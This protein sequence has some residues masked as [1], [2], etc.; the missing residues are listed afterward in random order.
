MSQA[1]GI[2]RY[3]L[4]HYVDPARAAGEDELTIRAGDVCRAM[5]LQG[6]TPNVCSVLGSRKFLEMAGLR[7]LGRV[8]PAQSTTTTYCYALGGQKIDTESAPTTGAGTAGRRAGERPDPAVQRRGQIGDVKPIVVIACAGSKSA[9][10]GHLTLGNGRRI[11]FVADPRV[12]PR[13]GSTSY[14]HPDDAAHSGLTWR[15]VLAG[16]NRSP[17]GNPRGLL[18]AWRLYEP[19][20]YPRVY[21]DLV[22]MYG[23]GNV[24]ILSAGWGLVAAGFLLPDYDITFAAAA[25]PEKRRRRHHRFDDFA[26]L[27]KMTTHP[28]VFMGGKDYVQLFCSLTEKAATRKIVF[29]YS[30]VPPVATG[31]ELRRY[32]A[33]DASPRTWH[34]QCAYALMRGDVG[35]DAS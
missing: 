35:I 21:S 14:R 10:T 28:V 4:T 17:E 9:S 20:T 33:A 6:R 30:S 8:G 22:E 16:Y 12:A 19:R 24:F 2:R 11:K 29:H 5:G 25:G 13:V 27:P 15:Q 23:L 18:P 34:Y 3:V 32:D 1:E 26:M 31:C 7:L